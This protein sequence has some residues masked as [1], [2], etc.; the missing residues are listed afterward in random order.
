[1]IGV[2]IMCIRAGFAV[3]YPAFAVD[4]GLSTTEATGSYA[5]SMPIYSLSVIGAGILLDRMG[6][7]TTM[8]LGLSFQTLGLV[9]AGL[10]QDL[11]QLYLAWGLLIGIGMSGA[12]YV[13]N[14]KMLAVAAPRHVGLGLGVLSAGQGVGALLV[15]PAI[16]LMIEI[17]GWRFAQVVLGLAIAAMLVPFILIAAPGRQPRDEQSG[18]G[19]DSMLHVVRTQPV[20]FAWAFLGLAAMGFTLLLPT[21][22]VA[23]LNETGM[24]AIVAAMVGGVMGGMMS[25]GGVIG[26][27]LANRVGP[28]RLILAG[29]MMAALGALMLPLA[30]PEAP[31]LV[32]LYLVG[33]GA[34]R[35]ITTVGLGSIQARVFP[36]ESLGRIS[37]LLEIGFGMG[38][39]AGPWLTAAG[40]DALGSYVP[41][42]LSAAP[43]ALLVAVGG[44]AAWRTRFR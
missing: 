41:G 23:Y 3:M 25:V 12:G 24:P 36:K 27:W 5:M 8:L 11:T 1:M 14:L 44:L 22:Q 33:A 43:A 7:R 10:A 15:S 21:H 31:L 17:G 4:L 28:P 37:G 13:A 16:Q 42:I 20:A 19:G 18:T 35:G 26:G 9:L 40:R 39:L 30:G 38:G 29:G 2:G 32:V 34:G 6:I